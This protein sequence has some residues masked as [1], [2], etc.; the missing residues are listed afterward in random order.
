MTTPLEEHRARNL[1]PAEVARIEELIA[2][3]GVKYIYYQ[4]VSINGRVLAKVVPAVHLRRNLEKGVQFHGTAIADLTSDRNGKLMGGGAQAEEFTILPDTDTFAVLP[5]DNEIGRFFCRVYRRADRAVDPGTPHPLDCRGLLVRT[6]EAFTARTGFE[7]RSGTEPEMS[8]I[9][10]SVDVVSRPGVSPAYHGLTLDMMRPVFKRVISYAQALGLDMVEGDYEDNGQ[11]EL[12]WMFDN[13]NATSDRLI[14]YRQIC[15]QVA[16]ELGVIASFMPKPFT[17]VMGNGCHH[18]VS[19]WRGDENVFMDKG[20]QELH[21]TE[22]AKHALGGMLQHAAGSMMVMASTVNSYKRY[23]DVGLFAPTGVDWGLDNKSCSVRVSAIGRLEYKIPDASV[24]PYLSHTLLL[25]A[26]ERGLAEQIDPGAPQ[27]LSSYETKADNPFEPLPT[28]LGDAIR[29]FAAD[30]L[31]TGALGPEL[32]DLLIEY[33][34]DEWLRY[35]GV[36]SDWER[37][38]YLEFMP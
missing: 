18:N 38:M 12:N 30:D 36:V 15:R 3:H 16:K 8:W 21:V 29:A 24:N 28:T 34:T 25:A 5:W 33:K 19:L 22:T 6:H 37:E 23:S 20:T 9:G 27:L 11:L 26:M 1:E 13:A 31:V 14:T 7:L 32:S 35:C 17:G 4:F 2:K 10:E